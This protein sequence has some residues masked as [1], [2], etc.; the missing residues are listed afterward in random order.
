MKPWKHPFPLS[1]LYAKIHFIIWYS[2]IIDYPPITLFITNPERDAL[3]APIINSNNLLARTILR[4]AFRW[5]SLSSSSCIEQI[6]IAIKRGQTEGE[7]LVSKFCLKACVELD[8]S[9]KFPRPAPFYLLN[10]SWSRV[11]YVNGRVTAPPEII[12][13][14]FLSSSISRFE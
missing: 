8:I 9:A 5:A 13:P 4:A 11:K 12:L 10:V 2:R 3:N 6:C 14:S 7:D 1:T